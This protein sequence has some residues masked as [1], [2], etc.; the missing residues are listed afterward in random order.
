MVHERGDCGL[1][2]RAPRHAGRS[3]VLVGTGHCDGVD[4]A[5]G[6]SPGAATDQGLIGSIL[7]RLWLDLGITNH[8]TL[9]RRAETL[10]VPSRTHSGTEQVPSRT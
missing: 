3:A 8:S 4:V 1:A 10:Q 9:S 7:R 5:R 6:V 2:R